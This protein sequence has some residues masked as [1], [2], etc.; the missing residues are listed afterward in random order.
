MNCRD[1]AKPLNSK[2]VRKS[3]FY[4]LECRSERIKTAAKNSSPF[5]LKM[6]N[7]VMAAQRKYGRTFY[8]SDAW[9]RLRYDV[10]Q[11][12]NGHCS[13]C[14][15][16]PLA[17]GVKLHVDHIKPRSRYPELELDPKNLQVL[18]R[19]CNMGKG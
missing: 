2:N 7:Y 17:D 10:L 12:S 5:N 9:I 14:G 1:C 13:L 8:T 4:C 19:D 3:I 15:R 16:G 18:C 6:N 11:R